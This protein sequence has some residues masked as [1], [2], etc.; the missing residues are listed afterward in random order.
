MP[1]ARKP[2]RRGSANDRLIAAHRQPHPESRPA[3]R[4]GCHLEGAAVGSDDL[5]R[6][7][8]AKPQACARAPLSEG[9]LRMARHRIEDAKRVFGC[10]GFA[11][12]VDRKHGMVAIQLLTDGYR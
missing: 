1:E 12:V 2:P 6:D 4:R 11:L 8:Q 3:C 10:D 9:K 5:P 7:E